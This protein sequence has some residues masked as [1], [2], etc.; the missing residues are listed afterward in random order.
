MKLD[1][2]YCITSLPNLG[3]LGSVPPVGLAELCVYLG[4][5]RP[6][7][8]LAECLF[9][10]ED[11]LQREAYLAGELS[12]V[13]PAVLTEQ[14]VRD[15]SPLP[16][17]L[18]TET[19]PEDSDDPGPSGSSASPVSTPTA[20]DKHPP[21]DSLWDAYFH[22]VARTA[23]RFRCGFLSAW[24]SHEVALRNAIVSVRADRLG[25]DETDYLVALDLLEDDEQVAEIV[26][27]WESAPTPLAGQRVLIRGRWTWLAEHD[28]Y[29]SFRNDEVAAYAARLMLLH[30]WRRISA[31][32]S[33]NA[34][35]E[36][37]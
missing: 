23:Q 33:T 26:G 37:I 18:V 15:E 29:Y 12:K 22:H 17:Y 34:Q 28:G 32:D 14:Q 35:T 10:L 5:D 4:E 20:A 8:Q 16:R 21:A 13:A 7:Q 36:G 31:E 9:L 6:R 30:E 11:L 3:E 25:L 1:R 24:V 27:D 19:P 2:Y